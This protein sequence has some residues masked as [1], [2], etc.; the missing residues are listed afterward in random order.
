MALL[1]RPDAAC[2]EPC[3]LGEFLLAQSGSETVLPE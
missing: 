3:P 1:E 2:A